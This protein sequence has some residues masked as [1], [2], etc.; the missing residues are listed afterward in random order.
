[1]FK[2]AGR[3]V[4][5]GTIVWVAPFYNR[6]GYG[7]AA[8]A[9]VSNLRRAGCRIRIVPVDEV[10]PGID[11]CDLDLFRSLQETPMVAPVT[12]IISHV[13]NRAWLSL[14]L[15]EPNLRILSTTFDSGVQ[16]NLPPAEWIGVCSRMDQLWLA[17]EKEKQVFVSAGIPSEKILV[18]Q[19]PHPWL[20]NAALPPAAPEEMPGGRFRF[21]S[22]AMFQPRRRWDTLVEAYLQ[23]F[24]G[25]ENVELYLKVNYPPWH[26]VPGK[27]RADLLELIRR[28]REKTASRA[29][30][31]VDDDLGTRKGI[32]E[33]ID[34]CNA[35][36]STDTAATAPI[37]EAWVR[38]R[39]VVVTGGLGLTYPSN[40][41]IQIRV[42]PAARGPLT[43]EML[44]YQ[45]H[46]K[47]AFMPLLHVADVRAALRT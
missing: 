24:K 10:D 19:P 9:F 42:D 7:V 37:F 1:M 13:P 31:T 14:K 35:Y 43:K 12:A 38:K 5:P 26:P 30:I 22:I 2:S 40:C 11:D 3:D 18:V 34:G 36:V 8:R 15:P 28:L 21:L 16:G 47:D 46:H 29:K 32:V 20:E 17:S 4:L 41:F 27:P 6:S 33:V 45:P 44:E 23:E 39:L 25:G